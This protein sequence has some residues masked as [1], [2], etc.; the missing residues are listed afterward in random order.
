MPAQAT[1]LKNILSFTGLVVGVPASLPH[2]LNVNGTS[3]DPDLVLPDIVGGFTVTADATNV[4]VTRLVGSP[5]AVD[6]Y[7]ER[8][9]TIEYVT[10]SGGLAAQIPFVVTGGAGGNEWAVQ[11][12]AKWAIAASTNSFA[13]P[14]PQ[15]STQNPYGY[16]HMDA[17][18]NL[19]ALQALAPLPGG[20][21][22]AQV[23]AFANLM[24][25]YEIAHYYDVGSLSVD[26]GHLAVDTYDIAALEAVPNATDLASCITLITAIA[27]AI[28]NHGWSDV[29]NL[30]QHFHDD[31]TGQTTPSSAG[32]RYFVLPV[33]PPV[34]LADCIADCNAIQQSMITHFSCA[35]PIPTISP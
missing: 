31:Q 33:A 16:A 7:V 17:D 27:L 9:H 11:I 8:W 24:K 21:T 1:I 23:D 5:A 2:L 12:W 18:K 29:E 30:G 6:V 25:H 3:V 28:V 20:A 4:T 32:G 13:D 34:T 10:P 26:G 15:D 35:V 22:Q 14:W 19:P